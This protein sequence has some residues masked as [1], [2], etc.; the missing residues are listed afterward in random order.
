MDV[1]GLVCDIFMYEMGISQFEINFLY[2]DL[3]L[4]VDQIF[5]F[6]YLF[7]EVVFKY[8]LIVVCMVKLLVKMLGSLMYIYQSI[9]ELDGG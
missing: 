9:V 1:L 7:K 5:L 3:V 4:L 8:G 6:K 2:G